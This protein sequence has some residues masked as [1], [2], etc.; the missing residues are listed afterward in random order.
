MTAVELSGTVALGAIGLLTLNLL[1][2]LLLSVG[3]NPTRHWP[4]RNAGRATF[5]QATSRWS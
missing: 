5:R 1:L 3:Y 2:G 4:R